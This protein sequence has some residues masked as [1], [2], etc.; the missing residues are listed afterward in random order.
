M[1]R[2]QRWQLSLSVSAVLIKDERAYL[3]ISSEL[4]LSPPVRLIAFVV[5]PQACLAVTCTS[6]QQWNDAYFYVRSYC[7]VFQVA[8]PYSSVSL[9][10]TLVYGT[11]PTTAST[12]TIAADGTAPR[13]TVY[14]TRTKA[15]ITVDIVM[16]SICSFLLAIAFATGGYNIYQLYKVEQTQSQ[17]GSR[18]F[19]QA[20]TQ[21]SH[22]KSYNNFEFNPTRTNAT[23]RSAFAVGP[24]A[25][26][27]KRSHNLTHLDATAFSSFPAVTPR[28]D[29]I[30]VHTA[31]TINST[32]SSGN[33]GGFPHGGGIA[34]GSSV[35][36]AVPLSGD[37]T[38][39]INYEMSTLPVLKRISGQSVHFSL[40]EDDDSDKDVESKDRK[41]SNRDNR[42]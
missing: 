36:D 6:A 39:H 41:F 34:S 26:G 9:V 25:G 1:C 19:T 2:R 4:E 13:A 10:P 38:I 30:H 35:G 33:P 14:Y 40:E 11:A 5:I 3:S 22:V 16:G 28:D 18:P 27:N 23:G 20:G 21:M 12:A 24:S 7:S 32:S 42:I 17:L 29:K 15:T 31:T 8:L 37:S